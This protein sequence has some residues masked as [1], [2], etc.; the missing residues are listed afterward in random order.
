[1][2]YRTDPGAKRKNAGRPKHT[3]Q[4]RAFQKMCHYFE[5]NNKEQ[6]TVT[7]L[8]EKNAGIFRRCR[9]RLLW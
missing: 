5:E 4:E 2:Q 9:F 7:D 1:M 8:A 6:L 3:D